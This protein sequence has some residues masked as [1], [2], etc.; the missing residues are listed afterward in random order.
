[1]S[2][3]SERVRSCTPV[4]DG[5]TE[6]TDAGQAEREAYGADYVTVSPQHGVSDFRPLRQFKFQVQLH[7]IC[8]SFRNSP[9]RRRPPEVY[10]PLISHCVASPRRCPTSSSRGSP[11]QQHSPPKKATKSVTAAS[12]PDNPIGVTAPPAAWAARRRASDAAQIPETA[13]WTFRSSARTSPD[14]LGLPESSCSR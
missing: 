1:M 4:Q 3:F 9:R 2:D 5:P 7:R 11:S 14:R 13:P 6:G 10:Q 12:T 8:R